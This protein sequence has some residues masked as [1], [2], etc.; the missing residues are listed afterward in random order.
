MVQQRDLVDGVP[1]LWTP[2]PA[3]LSAGLVF[4]V[5]RRDE[6]F[7]RG[8]LT[9]LVEHLA[10]GS[11]G[12][13]TL[14]C[15][16]TVDLTT[17]EFTASGQAARVAEFLRRI[18]EALGDLPLD[19][20]A[21]EVD[22]LRTE[23]G[24]V[25]PPAV[26]ALLAERYGAR[27]VG[28][29][30]FREPAMLSLTAQHVQDWARRYFVRGN[31]ALWLTGPPPEGL[32][33]PL[34]EG[35]APDRAPQPLLEVATPALVEHP[36]DGAVALGS[37]APRLPGLAAMTRILRDR[38]EDDLR[39]RRGLSYSVATE[40]VV[41][42]GMRRFVAVTADCRD[43]QEAV[44][45]R[46]LW[47]AAAR[48][49]ESGAS[50]QELAHQREGLEEYLADER[51]RTDEV[52]SAAESLVIGIE[53]R[54]PEEL[55]RESTEL[56]GDDVRVAAQALVEGALVGVPQGTE[57]QLAALTPIRS[58]GEVLTG[59]S[60][61]RRRIGSDAPRGSRLVVGDDGVTVVLTDE[62]HLT[63]R[64][65]DVVALLEVAPREWT[66][67][68]GDGTS[69]P[70]SPGDW[71]DGARAVELVRSLVPEALQARADD[72]SPGGRRVLLVRAAPSAAFE[73]LWPSK[74][75]AWV[76]QNDH[77]TV[78]VRDQDEEEAYAHAAGISSMVGRRGGVLLLEQA[79]DELRV[80]VFQRG[81]ER[82]RHV[83]T[84]EEHD[85]SVLSGV[86]GEDPAKVASL[87]ALSGSPAEVLATLSQELA[88]PEQTAVLLGGA[89]PADVPGVR[90]ERARGVR[91][92]IAA[93]A[94]GDFDP[95]DST[96]LSHR[97]S[98][99]ER[100][101]RPAYRLANGAA[102]AAQGALAVV[103]ASRADGDWTSW[104]GALAAVL[105]LSALGS[106]WS[107]RPPS[108][109][110]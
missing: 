57:L 22:V 90:H 69:V 11:L 27:G 6:S 13:T 97:L 98:R 61:R 31:A 32:S 96:K 14:D 1:V 107:T 78:A 63:V 20:L 89:D 23:G 86:L 65:Q 104:S 87:L 94:R 4:G 39:H 81:K 77:W 42:E 68:G 73:A 51:S 19:R 9:H 108:S 25:A 72:A 101:R 37:E 70:L 24:V 79:Y 53:H 45:A 35:E 7:L 88:V 66:L 21:V 46:A 41:V 106:L 64:F 67:V 49:A 71:R 83:W 44:V 33:L 43:G 62:E 91:E 92:S 5:G 30:G 56:T 60:F 8:G 59:E 36:F 12:R 52:R 40:Q 34:V 3:P 100:E 10:M 26:G 16:A 84:G 2:A 80:V 103:A 47:Q 18:C 54:T 58:S 75:D 28:L 17:T 99:W 50:E 110:A 95:P 48:L 109:R 105:G 93:A 82:D 29:A 15:N 76:V 55:R 74:Q 85:P 38:V 102:A